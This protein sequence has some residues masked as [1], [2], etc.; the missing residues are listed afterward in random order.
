[1]KKFLLTAVLILAVVTSLTAGTLAA[2]NQKIDLTGGNV[3]AKKFSF[4]ATG[5]KGFYD[6]VDLIPGDTVTYKFEIDNESE[7]K[8]DFKVAAELTGD[9]SKALKVEITDDKGKV[10]E[11]FKNVNQ[12]GKSVFFV[13]TSWPFADTDEANERDVSLSQAKAQL[14]VS[15]TGTSVEEI[16][17]HQTSYGNAE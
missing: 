5:T 13:T 8:V 2:Y 3:T 16:K 4:T 17:D 6:A 14:K 10:V 12:K 11:G 7:I 9:L 1:M 15:V